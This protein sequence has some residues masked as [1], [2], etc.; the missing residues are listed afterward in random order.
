MIAGAVLAL[1][2]PLLATHSISYDDTAHL[3]LISKVVAGEPF[4]DFRNL[5][6]PKFTSLNEEWLAARYPFFG[7][8]VACLSFGTS[9]SF[10]F[11]YYLLEVALLTAVLSKAYEWGCRR[12]GSRRTGLMVVSVAA[13][14]LTAAGPDNYFNYG[15]YPLQQGKLLLV[16]AVLYMILGW[17]RNNGFYE[18]TLGIG[19]FT[20]AWLHHLNLLLICGAL[21]P[22]IVISILLFS[23]SNRQRLQA[24]AILAAAFLLAAP[25]VIWPQKGI[26]RIEKPEPEISYRIEASRSLFVGTVQAAEQ[27]APATLKKSS[28]WEVLTIP[29]RWF[30]VGKYIE[31]YMKRAFSP[32]LVLFVCSVLFLPMLGSMALISVFYHRI[33]CSAHELAGA[34][35]VSGPGGRFNV[36]I[37]DLLDAQRISIQSIRKSRHPKSI[38]QTLTRRFT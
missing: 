30:K 38:G 13:F 25:A 22:L 28:M 32:E 29:F 21:V 17:Y 36:S 37:R 8:L 3:D 18:Y 27:S 23:S 9:F 7:I 6:H 16:T 15:V 33:V 34:Q 20:A 5:V 11:I 35:G 1:S 12:D 4:Q 10:I 26:L 14:V 2:L 31:V 19:L 24:G